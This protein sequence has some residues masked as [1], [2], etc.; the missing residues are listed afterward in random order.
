MICTTTWACTGISNCI[1]FID[2]RYPLAVFVF[3][4]VGAQYARDSREI[5]LCEA[6][7]EARAVSPGRSWPHG[8]AW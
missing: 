7:V 5:F 3:A 1:E 2:R 8:Q 4:D 6:D